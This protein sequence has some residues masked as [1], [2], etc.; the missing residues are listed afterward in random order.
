MT[1]ST[2]FSALLRV[3]DEESVVTLLTE[4][5][6]A[7]HR[8]GVNDRDQPVLH[9]PPDVEPDKALLA[10]LRAHK[11]ELTA[12]LLRRTL[13]VYLDFETWSE[14]DLEEVGISAYAEH[15]STIVLNLVWAIG[16]DEPQ[17]WSPFDED[18]EE[19]PQALLA[20]LLLKGV[21]FCA[22]NFAF[23]RAIWNEHM[24]GRY[25]WPEILL[26]RWSCTAFRARLARLPSGLDAI[27]KILD[28]PHQKDAAGHKLIR[29]ITK[30]ANPIDE[31][32]DDD[33]DQ[34]ESYVLQDVR[35][36]RALDQ[37]L[38]EIPEQWQSIFELD[39][40]I[41]ERGFPADLA[42]VERLILVRDAEQRR[43]E[44]E[45]RD[46]AG[47]GELT[48][49]R[50]VA[51]LRTKLGELGVD[52]PSLK[53]EV[54]E[55]WVEENPKR[56]DLA[57]RLIRNRLESAHSSDAKLDRITAT[58]TGSGRVRDGFVL[59]GAHTGRWAGAG[60][61]L[62]NLPKAK[63]ADPAEL[64]TKLLERAD[65]I[66]AGTCDPLVDPGWTLSIKESIANALRGCFR[67]PEGWRF[68]AVDFSQIESRV[69]CWIS[70]QEDKL[71]LY[72]AGDDVYLHDARAL[73][74]DS[75]DLG[76]LFVLSAGYG[77]SGAV[78]FK[79]A[80]GFGVALSEEDA[81][82]KT[83]RW[84]ENNH[85][86]VTFWYELYDKVRLALDLAPGDVV[87][88]NRFRIWRRDETLYLQL[89]SGRVLK[90]HEPTLEDSDYGY[91]AKLTVELPKHKKLLPTGLWH[92]AVTENVVSA[93]AV[94]LLMNAMLKLDQAGIFLIGSVHDE[95][96]AL[97]PIDE[98]EAIRD[99]M[100]EVMEEP[101]DW[102]E[103]LPLA[104]EGY[105]NE[106][107]IKPPK[108]A[109]APLPPSSAERWMHCPGSVAATKL[110]GPVPES[111]FALE[112]TEAHRIFAACLERDTDPAELTDD[113][114]IVASLRQALEI[115][116]DIIAGRKFKVEVRLESL[117][118]LAKV[119]GTADVLVFDDED[120]VVA[121]IDLKFGAGVTVE[122]DSLQVKIYSLLAAQKYG[123]SFEGIDLHIVQPRRVH[124][125]GPHRM[126]HI[127][128]DEL[129]ALAIALQRAVEAT[130]DP[131]A[132]R[133]A[134]AWCRFCTARPDCPEARSY[135]PA[136]ATPR[137]FHDPLA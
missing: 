116:R 30:M 11:A 100:V 115:T 52:L 71:E 57:A 86:I 134:G 67:A 1:L 28:L 14:V 5:E 87:K 20:A 98:A 79:R 16:Q 44:K 59:H 24:V 65:A 113:F 39:A 45:F 88:F 41:N 73:D 63:I 32:T 7:G 50:Q 99:Y 26:E 137:V 127:T 33:W 92:G 38:P 110:V 89:P 81:Y 77:A 55:T 102:A 18:A 107:F 43:L 108:A 53:R 9:S 2:T 72:R 126:H 106:R 111:S 46:L 22:H 49:P 54:L 129:D 58:A 12:E 80:A 35:A 68:V 34:L 61:Q 90:Y 131:A 62:Q 96:V 40:R 94:D 82:A 36:L 27:G 74:S 135:V 13:V 48:S 95:I 101:P 37:M 21:R 31:M 97:A 136:N 93:I 70:G 56:Q 78:L 104:A 124:E 117:P 76:K 64:L 3:G 4:V 121:I 84:R 132:P 8:L 133:V 130:E 19:I 75:R 69:L 114:F 47:N 85:A 103:D 128:T 83:D 17:I 123:C 60:V 112:G 66:E 29:R 119:W 109:H 51:K 23:D 105:V 15:G 25:E 125:R 10:R 120:A 6:A 118:G 122:P 91:S 42:A